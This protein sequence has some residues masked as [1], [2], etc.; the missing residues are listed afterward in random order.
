MFRKTL[1][2]L[3]SLW[4][5]TS[6]AAAELSGVPEVPRAP[7]PLEEPATAAGLA[8]FAAPALPAT[9]AAPAV[10]TLPAA[11]VAQPAAA[12]S[13]PKKAAPARTARTSPEARKASLDAAFDN[14]GGPKGPKGMATSAFLRGMGL[15]TAVAAAIPWHALSGPWAALDAVP[16]AAGLFMGVSRIRLKDTA[17][18]RPLLRTMSMRQEAVDLWRHLRKKGPP[19]PPRAIT[20]WRYVTEFSRPWPALRLAGPGVWYTAAALRVAAFGSLLSWAPWT[21]ARVLGHVLQAAGVG[22]TGFS[23]YFFRDPQRKAVLPQDAVASPA[24]GRVLSVKSEAPGQVTIRIFLSALNVH[25]Q[26]APFAGK[27]TNMEYREGKFAV[28]SAPEAAGKNERNS[29]RIE[30]EGGR[31]A[32]VDQLT[33]FIARRIASW[34]D[35]GDAVAQGQRTGMIFFGSQVALHLPSSARVQ[36]KPGDRVVGGRT[37]LALWPANK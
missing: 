19:S 2:G 30:G 32:V 9:A 5:A 26:R 36:V 13:Q 7:E 16:V 37:V 35:P 6:C 33:G 12:A 1:A 20:K 34:V 8:A 15:Y 11:A 24:D 23:A 10:P 31:W 4:L 29:T 18:D 17:T 3:A 27:V 21:A 14:S 25:V 28:A 22:L